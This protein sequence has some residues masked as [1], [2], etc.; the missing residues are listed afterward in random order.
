MAM[1][2]MQMFQ[3][4]LA[5]H[6]ASGKLEQAW[7][8]SEDVFHRHLVGDGDPWTGTIEG[9]LLVFEGDRPEDNGTT[10][11]MYTLLVRENG[12]IIEGSEAWDWTPD[13]SCRP[14]C[15]DGESGVTG[16]QV[17]E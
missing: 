17:S 2:A 8:L 15:T 7:S 3:G 11:D 12:T 14:A 5:E 9:N 6:R 1:P 16:V 10:H 4:W 13:G